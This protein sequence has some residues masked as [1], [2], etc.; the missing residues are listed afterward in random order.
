M[1]RHLIIG[2]AGHVD[3][4]KTALIKALTGI[5]CDTHKE[6]KERGI[7]I[8]LGFAH[9]DLPSGISVGIVDVPGHKDFIRTMVAGAFGID[10]VLLVIAAD[11]GIMPQTVEHLNIIEMLG[12]KHGIVVLTKTDLVDEETLELA[13][14]EVIDYL[15]G[16]LFE[17]ASIVEV[18]SFTGTGI[19]LLTRQIDQLIP[20]IPPREKR[21]VFRMYID[22]I[23]NLKGQGY[24]VTGSV[25][26]GEIE[27]GQDVYLLPGKDKK[28][29]IRSIERHGLHV[30]KVFAGDRA[31]L[32][33]SGIKAEDFQRGMILANQIINDSAMIDASL[34]LFDV[35][36]Q[37]GMWSQVVFHSGTF[38]C[39]ARLHLLDK[40][41]LKAKET[42][43]VQI[44]LDKPAVLF[45]NDKFIIRNSSGDL[46]LGGGTVLDTSP[47]HHKRRTPQLLETLNELVLARM[48]KDNF[49]DQVKLELK[50]EGVPVSI[51]ILAKKKGKTAE[52]IMKNLSDKEN[53]EVRL[54]GT[55]GVAMLV[56]ADVDCKYKEKIIEQVHLWHE[57]NSLVEEGMD[58]IELAGK[59]GLNSAIGKTYLE[60][61]LNGLMRDGTIKKVRNTWA[62]TDHQIKIDPKT[63]EQ[64]KWL[65]ESVRDFGMQR[66]SNEEIEALALAK[67]ITKNKLK[68][69]VNYLGKQKRLRISGE[70]YLHSSLVD[71]CRIRILRILIHKDQGINEKEFR[72]L[73]GAT[74]KITQVLIGIFLSEGLISKRT[75]YLDITEK[76]KNHLENQQL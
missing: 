56:H 8:N 4:G 58:I 40:E 42:A 45:N 34:S 65:E 11:S 14:L 60:D 46:T 16:S 3:H 66:P 37:L 13:K 30:T 64:M 44:H 41:Q 51:E 18:S 12:I 50:K 62:L 29:K 24:V 1:T 67:G 26:D 68:M 72:E 35:E 36:K 17:N 5:D 38:S 71:T 76:G 10:M 53:E 27:T 75:Y 69:M 33:L 22:R 9:L 73:A 74:K 48:N 49:H 70:D 15:E 61:L 59:I 31:A 21:E 52:D 19:D 25:L 20:L 28:L 6:E 47:L 57:R 2:T 55:P 39:F 43:I 32:N 54:Y 63:E 23:F 7:T